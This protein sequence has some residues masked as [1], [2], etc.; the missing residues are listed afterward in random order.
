VVIINPTE[1]LKQARD[2]ERLS[3]AKLLE[4]LFLTY[5]TQVNELRGD[6]TIIYLSLADANS[7]CSSFNLPDLPLLYIYHCSSPDNLRKTDGSGW[8][9][10]DFS[11]IPG[12]SPIPTLPIDPINDETYYYTYIE[13][14]SYKLFTEMES[15]TYGPTSDN[16]LTVK[17][18]GISSLLY[19]V[20]TDLKLSSP[21][22]IVINGEID[23]LTS[24]YAPAWDANLNGTYRPTNGFSSGYNSGVQLPT[25][26]YHAHASPDCGIN[27]SGCLEYI[28]ENCAIGYCHRWL[29]VSQSWSSPGVSK[30]WT[31]GTKI[32]VRFLAKKNA[33]NK[34][35][36][37]G[38]YHYSISAGGNTFAGGGGTTAQSLKQIGDWEMTI[39][40]FTVT[41]DWELTSHGVTLYIYG[42]GGGDEGRVWVDSVEMV[43][44]N[45]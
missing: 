32:R 2:S 11:S 26:G 15:V 36:Y 35:P 29:G 12:G 20:G 43:Y 24:G 34:Y 44:W 41:S 5:T 38:I 37:F 30:G 10:V 18:G 23:N 27:D 25:I 3:D 4:K 39:G 28:D 17:D 13:G 22:N 31:A 33:A 40:E 16:P 19:E 45:P 6:P 1:L 42:I 8:I 7:D 9:P 14:G 21:A